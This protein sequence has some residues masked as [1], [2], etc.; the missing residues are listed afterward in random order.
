MNYRPLFQNC[1]FYITRNDL[2]AIGASS[3][4]SQG[5]PENS[6]PHLAPSPT[7]KYCPPQSDCLLH[8][9]KRLLKFPWLQRLTSGLPVT[10][11]QSPRLPPFLQSLLVCVNRG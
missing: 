7:A 2:C 6:P 1:M 11:T 3:S 8:I 4:L 9:K 10:R 5:S